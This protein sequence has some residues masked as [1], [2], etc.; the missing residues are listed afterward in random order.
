[1]DF[2]FVGGSGG[3]AGGDPRDIQ[4]NSKFAQFA[5][6]HNYI[7]PIPPPSPRFAVVSRDT[8][9]DFY[10]DKESE[11]A[12]D[13][14]SPNPRDFEG[15]RVY[16][17]DDPDTLARVAQFDAA[18]DT[19]SFNTGFGAVDLGP[20]SMLVD[21]VM[22]HYKFT[23]GRLRNGFKYY[24]AVTA[25]DLGNS[26]IPPLESGVSQNR[27]VAVPGPMPLERPDLGPTVFPNPYRVE[28][29]WDQ[30]RNVRD[31][32]LWFANLPERCT[33]RIYTLAGD[34]LL[35]TEFNGASYHGEG[36]RG[37]YDPSTS[38]GKPTLSGTTFGWDLITRQGQAIATGLYLYSV[39]DHTQGNKHHVGKFLVVKS[40]R[41]GQ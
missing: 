6:D 22:A 20:D 1:V 10:W 21:G 5:Y 31:H 41:E 17:G 18:G 26:Q 30:G 15:Y 28:A 7:L 3:A 40:D 36:T 37:V 16:V 4:L 32:Y 12:Y 8:A 9:V 13:V 39:E 11:N 14:T 19:A 25:F 34:L 2:A 35:E 24:C 29:R 27:R 38:L 33:L 23:V